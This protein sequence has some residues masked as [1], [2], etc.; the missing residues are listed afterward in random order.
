MTVIGE[1]G[2]LKP[3]TFWLILQ[4]NFLLRVIS[5]SIPGY[6]SFSDLSGMCTKYQENSIFLLALENTLLCSI[7]TFRQI[8]SNQLLMQ[9][10][11]KPL[12]LPGAASGAVSAVIQYA[13]PKLR[14]QKPEPMRWLLLSILVKEPYY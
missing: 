5:T 11:E 2:N 12:H 1:P 4:N 3:D 10:P 8:P 14:V 7:F 6:R 9:T 13:R